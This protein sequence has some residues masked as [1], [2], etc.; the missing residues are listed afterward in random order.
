VQS[1]API[2][3]GYDAVPAFGV[4]QRRNADAGTAP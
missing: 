3:G 2:F 1:L 4:N